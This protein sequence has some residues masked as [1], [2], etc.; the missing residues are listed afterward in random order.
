VNRRG[1]FSRIIGAGVAVG[2]AV[3]AKKVEALPVPESTPILPVPPAA[4][5]YGIALSSEWD[6]QE[7]GMTFDIDS[8]VGHWRP[9]LSLPP[10]FW[11][12]ANEIASH[13]DSTTMSYSRIGSTAAYFTTL[14]YNSTGL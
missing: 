4:S 7:Y 13:I 10:V 8:S 2:A 1:F 12:T 9:T 6:H 11:S 3:V 5:D 14:N